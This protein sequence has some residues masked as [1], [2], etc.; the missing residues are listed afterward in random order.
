MTIVR[1]NRSATPERFYWLQDLWRRV[2]YAWKCGALRIL[3]SR[4]GMPGSACTCPRYAADP[5]RLRILRDRCSRGTDQPVDSDRRSRGRQDRVFRAV[6]GIWRFMDP[7]TVPGSSP[8]TTVIENQ[9][10]I[11]QVE[12]GAGGPGSNRSLCHHPSRNELPDRP[13]ACAI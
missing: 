7:P 10:P 5:N 2:E 4:V 9:D 13:A 12:I 1:L 3:G 6:A 8:R 11:W